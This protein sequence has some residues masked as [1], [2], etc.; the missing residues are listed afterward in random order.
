[1]IPG[2]KL[3]VVVGDRAG[4]GSSDEVGGVSW[5]WHGWPDASPSRDDGLIS[6]PIPT[7]HL[8]WHF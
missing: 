2:V 4:R 6:V 3:V 8:I 5:S 1:M 7:L